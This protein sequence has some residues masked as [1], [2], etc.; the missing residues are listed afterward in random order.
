MPKHKVTREINTVAIDYTPAQADEAG[1]IFTAISTLL[2][3]A[4]KEGKISRGYRNWDQDE[5]VTSEYP[6][7]TDTTE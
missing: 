5:D 3:D 1:R 2:E 7:P 6:N 4:E